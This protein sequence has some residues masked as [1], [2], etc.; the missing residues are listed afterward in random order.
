MIPKDKNTPNQAV[1][2]IASTSTNQTAPQQSQRP[3]LPV[4]KLTEKHKEIFDLESSK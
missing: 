2:N 3:P 1:N 4:K